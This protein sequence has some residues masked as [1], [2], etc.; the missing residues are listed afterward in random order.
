M[1]DQRW[2]ASDRDWERD[3]SNQGWRAKM[4]EWG[5]NEVIDEEHIKSV[6]EIK[7]LFTSSAGVPSG[8]SNLYSSSIPSCV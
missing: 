3:R 6:G 8:L 1:T 5:R 7:Q 4:S 2:N